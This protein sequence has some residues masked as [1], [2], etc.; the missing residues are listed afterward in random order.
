MAGQDEGAQEK[1]HEPTPHKLQQAREKGEVV[2][3]REIATLAA[4]LGFAIAL[5]AAGGSGAMSFAEWLRPLIASPDILLI[6]DHPE[7]V[8]TALGVLILT[9][10]IICLPVFLLP[11][12]MTIV[13][14]IAQKAIVFAPSK[15]APK[16][17][18]ISM[19]QNAKQ[20][21]GPPG[22]AEFLKSMVKL[23]AIA[24][25]IWFALGPRLDEI[26][27][28]I[29]TSPHALPGL[30]LSETMRLLIAV[31]VMMMAIAGVDYFWQRHLHYKKHS[32]SFQEI[33]DE[34]KHTEGDP[35]TKQ[36]RRERANE[37]ATSRMLLDVP[38]ADVV[39]MNPT[40]YAVALKWSRAAG[41]APVCLAKGLDEIAFRIREKAEGS[42]IPI[43]TDP[44][45]ARSLHAVV[46]V[47][48][49]IHPDHYRAVASA[50]L[51]ADRMR[52]RKAGREPA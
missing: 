42:G 10:A 30:L 20:K 43:H 29:A 44:P 31:I 48:A 47:G 6:W 46:D 36:R 9:I 32:M 39:I 38:R 26:G 23:F 17:S 34:N 50:I 12:L 52:A 13:G 11:A 24:A 3:S 28:L 1:S 4:Y 7:G 49:E 45:L 35:H 22:L 25:V 8:R 19:L 14:L 16:L 41:S 15:I 5:V 51:F 37:I 2:Q 40:H 27:S 18:R 33:K 21:F